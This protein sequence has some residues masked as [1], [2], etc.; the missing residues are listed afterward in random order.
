MRRRDFLR[1]T[2]IASAM[3]MASTSRSLGDLF[4]AGDHRITAVLYDE[5][6]ADC[7]AF[8]GTL[9]KRGALALPTRGDAGRLWYGHLREHLLRS[10]GSVAGMTTD[11]DWGLSRGCGREVGFT[12]AYEGSHDFRAG[13]VI[14]HS[15]R[16]HG[17]E[18]DVYAEILSEP[19]AWAASI[20]NALSSRRKTKQILSDTRSPLITSV[21][22]NDRLGYLTSWL[23]RPAQL[24]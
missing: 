11:S 7:R 3:V 18:D 1:D 20:A 21:S 5:R 6:S 2:A 4:G 14:S 10:P 9:A 12:V 24:A 17:A 8:A 15:L 19:I 22:T 16:G 13:G 23:L